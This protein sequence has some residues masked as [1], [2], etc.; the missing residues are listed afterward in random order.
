MDV[1]EC[2][3]PRLVENPEKRV[4]R[5]ESEVTG[6][7]RGDKESVGRT[8]RAPVNVTTRKTDLSRRDSTNVPTRGVKGGQKTVYSGRVIPEMTGG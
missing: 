5:G 1:L 8:K 3:G 4:V 7:W 2:V 6:D